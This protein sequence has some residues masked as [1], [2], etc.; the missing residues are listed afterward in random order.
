[1]DSLCSVAFRPGVK[2]IKRFFSLTLT[3]RLNMLERL[4]QGWFNQ[5]GLGQKNLQPTLG[6]YSYRPLYGCN[7]RMYVVS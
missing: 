5:G 4:S 3:K 2:V 7:L 6:C 1:M